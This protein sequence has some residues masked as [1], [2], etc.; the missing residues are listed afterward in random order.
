MQRLS[1]ERIQKELPSAPRPK[2]NQILHEELVS[3]PTSSTR[4]SRRQFRT[5]PL[6][7]PAPCSSMQTACEG[8]SLQSCS[9]GQTSLSFPHSIQLPPLPPLPP[10]LPAPGNVSWQ[11]LRA[12][13]PREIEERGQGRNQNRQELGRYLQANREVRNKELP[14]FCSYPTSSLVSL[15]PAD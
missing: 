15:S 6:H 4:F 11:P 12:D 14:C 10:P 1:E 3:N 7:P 5:H 8:T 2:G 13:H 9:F